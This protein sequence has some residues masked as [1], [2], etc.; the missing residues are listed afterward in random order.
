[1]GKKAK[2]SFVCVNDVKGSCHQF[3]ANSILHC[4]QMGSDDIG[5]RVDVHKCHYLMQIPKTGVVYISFNVN[6]AKNVDVKLRYYIMRVTL[7]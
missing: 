7:Y 5:C 3:D 1:M 2:P 6:I 4:L